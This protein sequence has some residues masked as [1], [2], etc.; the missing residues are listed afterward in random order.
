MYIQTT[1]EIEVLDELMDNVTQSMI[2]HILHQT[3][4]MTFIRMLHY[5]QDGKHVQQDIIVHEIILR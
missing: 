2:I 3:Y 1:M 4:I 5:M